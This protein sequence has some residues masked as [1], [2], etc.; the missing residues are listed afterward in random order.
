MSTTLL[1]IIIIVGTLLYY[2]ALATHFI[3]KKPVMRKV[4]NIT[5][6]AAWL[7]NLTVVINNW[8]VNGY[9]PFVTIFQ[10][11]TFIA[12]LFG[13]ILA[14][15]WFVRDAEWMKPFFIVAAA[16]LMTGLCFMPAKAE[17]T[18]RPAL[19]SIWFLPHVLLYTIA[20][21]LSFVAFLVALKALFTKDPEKKRVL[22]NGI[23]GTVCIAFPFM[24]LALCI[25]AVWANEI[26][27]AFWSW[28]NKEN[29]ALVSWLTYM[30]Y[31]HFRKSKKLAKYANLLVILGFAFVVV[32][33]F[34]SGGGQHSYL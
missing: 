21:T 13:P 28:D 32:T 22:D 14:Y 15:M 1:K 10:V 12:M 2:T 33:M 8:A 26:W 5:L 20:Y 16:I 6:G 9:V 23:Y 17:S 25:G 29:W 3:K 31:L 4:S 19:Q 24:T 30:L 27:G 18:F 34:F 11:L 7:L